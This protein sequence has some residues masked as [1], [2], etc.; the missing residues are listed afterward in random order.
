MDVTGKRIFEI[1]L[2]FFD[3]PLF[4]FCQNTMGEKILGLYLLE[5]KKSESLKE[6]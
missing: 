4:L 1:L 5:L 6:F 2:C 3:I